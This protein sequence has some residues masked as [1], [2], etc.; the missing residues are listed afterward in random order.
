MTAPTFLHGVETQEQ[1]LVPPIAINNMAVGGLIG[2]ADGAD[3]DVFPYNTPVL[4]SSNPQLAASLTKNAPGSGLT[5]GTLPAAVTDFYNEGGGALVAVRVQDNATAATVMSNIIGSQNTMTGCWAFKQAQSLVGV[6]PRT[7]MAPGYTATR[8]D[9]AENPVV[10]A[11]LII[12]AA[13]QGRVYAAGPS[14]DETDMQAWIEDWT[15]DRLTAFYPSVLTWDVASSAYVARDAAPANAGLLARVHRQQGFWWSPS[16]WAY[17]SVGGLAVPVDWAQGDYNSTANILNSNNI[18][19]AINMAQQGGTVGGFRRW[20]NRVPNAST[21]FEC[22]RTTMDA[23]E[24]ALQ[25][26][27]TW[28]NDKP[29]SPYIIEQLAF[30]ANSFLKSMVTAGALVGGDFWIDPND[31]SVNN[32]EEGIWTFRFDAE[33]A[34]PMEHIIN[35][36]QRNPHYYNNLLSAVIAAVGSNTNGG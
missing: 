28:A 2:T 11:L 24:M 21:I 27:C 13:L 23:I 10:A 31:N 19:T 8:P 16:N 25:T 15:S 6:T 18:T 22:V 3:P 33:P 29:P 17:N 30:Q 7:L 1:V 14:T 34:A 36:A 5:A 12:A 4:L 9:N 35:I 32:L 20:G 26:V